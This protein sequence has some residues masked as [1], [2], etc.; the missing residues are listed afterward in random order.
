MLGGCFNKVFD[1]IQWYGSYCQRTILTLVGGAQENCR[2]L[3]VESDYL[4]MTLD[5]LRNI[6]VVMTE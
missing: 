1:V 4:S 2:D 5:T 3:T 6:K